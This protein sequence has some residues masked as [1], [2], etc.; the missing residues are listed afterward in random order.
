MC[1]IPIIR[2]FAHDEHIRHSRNEMN[3]DKRS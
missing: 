3:N 2:D 1:V